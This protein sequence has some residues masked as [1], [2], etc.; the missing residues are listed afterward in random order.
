MTG[1]RSN[2]TGGLSMILLAAG[3]WSQASSSEG[4]LVTEGIHPMDYPRVLI[5]ILSGLGVVLTLLPSKKTA[6]DPIPIFSGRIAGMA[7]T[8]VLF[9]AILKIVGFGPSAFVCA[10]LC[11][12]IMGWRNLKILAL[13]NAAGCLCIW[14]L[15]TYA[16]KIPLPAGMLW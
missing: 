12:C 8:L 1:R 14:A 9:A 4:V 6:K 2:I 10:S 13:I 16:L 5:V 11:A 3:L 15:F 7:A